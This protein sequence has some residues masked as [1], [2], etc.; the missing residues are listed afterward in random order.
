MC[1]PLNIDNLFPLPLAKEVKPKEY[2]PPPPPFHNLA[3]FMYISD[4]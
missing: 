4:Q 2:A 3:H 1:D